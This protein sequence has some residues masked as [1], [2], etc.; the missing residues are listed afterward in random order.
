VVTGDIA[1]NGKPISELRSVTCRV[2]WHS[3]TCHP[4]PDTGE[5]ASP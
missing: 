5:C 1:L 3:V 2:G 4:S